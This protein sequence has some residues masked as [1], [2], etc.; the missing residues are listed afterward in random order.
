MSAPITHHHS[1]AAYDAC[2]RPRLSVLVPF[3][4]DDPAPLLEALAASTPGGVE[5]ILFDDGVPCPQLNAAVIDT[6]NGLDLPVLMISSRVNRGR[7]GARNRLAQAARSDWLLFLDADMAVD[8]SFLTR[9]ITHTRTTNA[10]ALFGGFTPCAP[11]SKTR[12]HA[13]LEEASN[14]HSIAQRNGIGPVAVC[15]SNLAVRADK[16]AETPF[17]EDFSGW[18]WEDVDWALTAATQFELAHVDNPARH[19]G[20]ETVDQ[21]LKKFGQSGP[22]FARLLQRHPAYADRPGARL[23]T[24]VKALHLAA[25]AR[26]AGS[27]TARL[28]I[29]P[30]RLRVL[31]VKLF[32]AGVAAEALS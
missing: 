24:M 18:G 29:L 22:N 12:L 1:N 15:S 9:W 20:L 4:T 19:G 14:G 11:T 6:V 2:A 30:I 32:R 21:L 28:P 17:D 26:T 23:A 3:H 13:A 31:G 8:S 27:L 5:F 10:G 16:F 7:S 25:F